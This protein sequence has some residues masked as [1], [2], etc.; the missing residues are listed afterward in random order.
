MFQLWDWTSLM[1]KAAN[2]DILQIKEPCCIM[3]AINVKFL[4]GD[5]STAIPECW[6]PLLQKSC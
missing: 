5:Q 4:N 3:L 6:N 1:E 2:V